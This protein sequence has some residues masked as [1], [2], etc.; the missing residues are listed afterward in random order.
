M[1]TVHA[2]AQAVE[3]C[4]EVR[5]SRRRGFVRPQGERKWR[6]WSVPRIEVAIKRGSITIPGLVDAPIVVRASLED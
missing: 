4:F 1:T 6:D 3:V 2:P 5:R